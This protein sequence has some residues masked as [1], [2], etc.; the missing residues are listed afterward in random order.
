M[1]GHE[2]ISR[3]LNGD[4]KYAKLLMM[5]IY[6]LGNDFVEQKAEEA[7]RLGKRLAYDESVCIPDVLDGDVIEDGVIFVDKPNK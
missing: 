3:D 2:I 7:E 4:R 5:L 1:T 6:R